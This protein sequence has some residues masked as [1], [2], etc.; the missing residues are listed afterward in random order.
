MKKLSIICLVSLLYAFIP[1]NT[2]SAP[3]NSDFLFETFGNLDEGWFAT[4]NSGAG[5]VTLGHD[6]T[7]ESPL[8]PTPT[9]GAL[10]ATFGFTTNNIWSDFIVQSADWGK[11]EYPLDGSH[12][13]GYPAYNVDIYIPQDYEDYLMVDQW[14]VKELKAR[15]ITKSGVWNWG[16][17]NFYVLSG[18]WNTISITSDLIFDVNDLNEIGIQLGSNSATT[19]DITAYVDYARPVPIPTTLLLFGSGLLGLVGLNRRK[20]LI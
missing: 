11:P 18:G 12:W 10:E 20:K 7:M 9:T 4:W 2:H 15:V 19:S 8:D 1:I 17:G 14:G 5:S 16:A 13:D 6:S 3:W